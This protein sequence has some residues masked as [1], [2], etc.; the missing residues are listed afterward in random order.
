[1]RIATGVEEQLASVKDD[2]IRVLIAGAGVAGLTLAAALRAEG[3]HPVVVERTAPDADEGYMLALMPIVDPVMHVIGADTEYRARSQ[4]LHHYRMRNRHGHILRTYSMDSLLATFGDYRGIARGDLLAV[5][6]A[7]G[8]PVSF[9]TRITDLEQTPDVVHASIADAEA[10]SV[11]ADFDL[12][13][14]ADGLHSQT[15]KLVLREDQVETFDSGWGGW[16]AWSESIPDEADL[17][18]EIWGA[19]FFLGTYPV[20]DR[21]GVIL[22]GD[23]RDTEIG[24]AQFVRR[25]RADLRIAD[26]RETDALNAV[27]SASD[28]YFWNLTDCR[29]ATWSVGRVG[30]IGDAAAGFLPTAGIGAAMAMEAAGQLVKR[31]ATT[32]RQGIVAMLQ[33]Y[34]RSE[35]PRVEAAQDNSRQLARLVFRRNEAVSA[36]RDV[37][38]RFIP[39]NVALGP[40]R[41]L[42]EEAPAA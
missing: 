4:P 12:V 40:I 15:R 29:A 21:F 10:R 2:R 37:A 9:K 20:K 14:A 41:K 26:K 13:I 23:R 18:D 6:S 34:E 42:H 7:T 33:D 17:S 32:D 19:G 1:M 16:V 27:A 3:L 38:A 25:A 24:P 36:V 30:L 8:V 31:I 35:R 28:P 11:G 5:L 22:C 39:L